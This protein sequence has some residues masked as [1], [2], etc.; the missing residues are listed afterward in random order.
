MH[1]MAEYDLIQE[2][3]HSDHTVIY[4]GRSLQKQQSVIIKTFKS[5]Y[6]TLDEITLLKH[7]YQ[8]A[9]NLDLE[10][11][12]KPLSLEN[13]G[14][15]LALVLEDVDGQSLQDYIK[16]KKIDLIYFLKIAIQ[17]AK[18]LAELRIRQIIHKDIKSSNI[19]INPR[20]WQ[21]KITD[22]ALCLMFI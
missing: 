19:I 15:G 7:E 14:N 8:I 12:I 13:Y 2:V 20:T 18:T 16:Y 5:E 4:R 11:I 3:Y 22:F 10:G 17:L 6:P 9:K 21:V 1:R